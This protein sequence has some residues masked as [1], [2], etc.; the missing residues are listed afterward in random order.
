[1]TQE[2]ELKEVKADS[3]DVLAYIQKRG[4][5]STAEVAAKFKIRTTQA[6]ANLAILRIKDAIE[7]AAKP[8]KS[9]DKTSRWQVKG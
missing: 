1:M 3:M 5:V 8:E 7:P 9:K 6:A 4:V 2:I